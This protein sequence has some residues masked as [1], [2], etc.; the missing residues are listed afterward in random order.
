MGKE[1]LRMPRKD[2]VTVA[3]IGVITVDDFN[4]Q[5]RENMRF[6]LVK[7]AIAGLGMHELNNPGKV[8]R[9]A[10]TLADACIAELKA[11]G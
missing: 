2:E 3:D 9:N 1:T 7:S 6:E 4:R 11:N 5:E 8:A 10:V